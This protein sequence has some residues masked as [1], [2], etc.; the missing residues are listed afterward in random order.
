M[1]KYFW[2][3]I[4]VYL[5]SNVV[6]EAAWG[7]GAQRTNKPR[8]IILTDISAFLHE[9]GEPDD[10]QSMV[11]LMLYSNELEIE[12][13]IATSNLRHGQRTRPEL[14]KQ[15]LDSYDKV[16]PNL[17]LHDKNYPSANQLSGR[18][19]KGTPIAS[20][21]V[22][23]DESIGEGK[24]TE[25]SDWIINVVDKEDPRPVWIAIWGG[26]ADL[27]QALWNVRATRTPDQ[28]KEFIAKLR[29]HAV[30]DQDA[31]GPWIREQF[32]GLFVIFRHHGI[33]GMYRGGDTT[34]VR[35]AWV[36]TNIR[37]NHGPLG[38][39][40]THYRGGDIWGRALGRV[41]GIKE[42]DTP[43]F[44]FLLS[45]GLNDP[46]H[47]EWGNWSG[48]FKRD[49]TAKNLWV[50]AIDSIA[51]FKTDM[52]PR[53]AALYRWRPAWQAD[54][55]ARLDWCVKP[56]QDA[57]HAPRLDI[58]VKELI[59]HAG[60]QAKLTS[61]A[62]SDPD[63]NELRFNWYFYPEAGTYTGVLPPLK[64]TGRVAFFTAPTVP[65]PQTIHIVLEVTDNGKP[66]LTSY[67]RFIVL[68]K[69]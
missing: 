43:S 49:S 29:V 57:N 53:M 2:L 8:L 34:L 63:N 38:A 12:G 13:L 25:G 15:V 51:N 35:S 30:Y 4:L 36:E 23:V 54:F 56:F 20:P 6:T 39:L 16:H 27:A 47:P 17:L 44:L 31:T 3:F 26:S 60:K 41:N 69:P 46:E 67:K 21:Q 55:E 18:V 59:T 33:R 37:N 28:V 65:S 22:P 1:D 58:N 62:A 42:G 9:E 61:P 24:D 40:Y 45:N 11:R 48:R 10:S 19:K 68:V 14:I 50:E 7:Q 66:A 52:D 32:P 64:A 5:I